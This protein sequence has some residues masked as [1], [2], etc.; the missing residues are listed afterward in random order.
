MH[1]IVFSYNKLFLLLI[2]INLVTIF[3]DEERCKVIEH[4]DLCPEI[5]RCETCQNGYTLNFQQT[6]CILLPDNNNI[7]NNENPNKSNNQSASSVKKSSPIVHQNTPM[8]SS[9]NN[10][11][12][13]VG[14]NTPSGIGK[15][16]K[17]SPY[18]LPKHPSGIPLQVDKPFASAFQSNKE[19]AFTQKKNII[20]IV[21]IL[22][23][24][25]LII[26]CIRCL[27]SRRKKSKGGFFYDESGNLE[28]AKVVYIQ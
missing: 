6:K 11:S 1:D 17:K 3:S 27:L 2:F 15:S 19:I 9:V 22:A 28:K 26:I 5:N 20:K 12:S 25:A 4:C 16:P 23:I 18:Y 14:Q 24:A 13:A 21:I 10:S 7:L 8:G